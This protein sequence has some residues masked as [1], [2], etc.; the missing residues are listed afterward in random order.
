MMYKKKKNRIGHE[1][2]SEGE[3]KS[4]LR[5]VPPLT[6]LM[7]LYFGGQVLAPLQTIDEP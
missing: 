3:K 2:E 6:T 4:K 7:C 5:L 1:R